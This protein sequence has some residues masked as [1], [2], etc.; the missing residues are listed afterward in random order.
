MASGASPTIP[1]FTTS[2]SGRVVD[3][4]LGKDDYV[5]A[6]IASTI[7]V[8]PGGVKNVAP[9][10]VGV[11][12]AR[13]YRSVLL[14]MTVTGLTGTSPL[15]TA[16]FAGRN[17]LTPQALPQPGTALG[18]SIASGSARVILFDS[19]IGVSNTGVA[20]VNS[21]PI[22]LSYWMPFFQFS[23]VPGGTI[24]GLTTLSTYLYGIR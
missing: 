22:T 2:M 19:A 1:N 7:W 8:G 14:L 4:L 11:F 24:S 3:Q 10:A 12:D 20:F 6:D 18:Q 17:D 9:A 23:V 21:E 15:L 13:P 5:L 16:Q